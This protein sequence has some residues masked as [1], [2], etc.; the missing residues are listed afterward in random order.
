MNQSLHGSFRPAQLLAFLCLI[1]SAG[2]GEGE[3]KD[4]WPKEEVDKTV[5][6]LLRSGRC[7]LAVF[8]RVRALPRAERL[9]QARKLIKSSHPVMRHR[10]MLEAGIITINDLTGGRKL[11]EAASGI[12]IV[13][14]RELSG[15]ERAQRGLFGVGQVAGTAAG[16]GSA[17]DAMKGTVPAPA[18]KSGPRPRVNKLA[19]D[20]KARGAAH[21]RFKRDPTTG[22]VSGYTTFDKAGRPIKRF[23][24]TGKP[25]G[26]VEPP[27]VY[28]PKPGKGPGA[29]L[30]RARPAI[31][32]ELPEGY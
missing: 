4:Q 14:N 26:G 13:D 19:P 1:C 22:K 32:Q 23:R 7:N 12:D 20:P 6:G 17:W 29:P 28:E 8:D 30:N 11:V 3:K 15:L 25:H 9:V 16:V 18:P 27:I 21:T 2:G 10:A 24:G 31:P 5:V